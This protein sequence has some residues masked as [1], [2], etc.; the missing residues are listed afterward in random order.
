[1]RTNRFAVAPCLL[2]CACLVACGSSPR[3]VARD[4]PDDVPRRPVATY[5]IVAMS[6]PTGELGVA[7]QS[8]WY[9]VRAVVPWAES[10]VG[11]VATQS[12]AEISYGPLGL[13]L[14]R[15]GRSPE[16]ALSALTS[17]DE[18]AAVRQVAMIDT[19]GNTAVHTGA[20]CIAHAGHIT[21]KA[22]DGSSFSCQSNLM[23]NQ[24]VPEAM[25]EAFTNSRQ[26]T[27]AERLLDALRAAE[28][29]GGD[30][31]GRQSAAILIVRANP[32]E[33]DW[34]NVLVDLSIEDHADPLDE[35]ARLLIL[36]R[37]YEFMDAGDKAIERG[38]MS[39]AQHAYTQ[40]L[41]LAPEHR[42]MQFWIGVSW[43]GM[44]DKLRARDMLERA[45][46]DDKADWREVLRRLPASG[47]LPDDPQLIEEM[48]AE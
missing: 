9:N 38:D 37:A 1:M 3:V 33:R 25:A 18:A 15:G 47:I 40:A 20:N 22:P 45:F 24:G 12:F 6:T 41:K 17:T 43:L 19:A 48:I 34:D 35:I 16:Q 42:E 11:A 28:A 46:Q 39:N 29:A 13:D 36:H 21:G 27:L 8:H 5:S 26:V 4:I 7:V 31:R 32:G 14:M 23:A 2:A 44:H 30:I 10:G